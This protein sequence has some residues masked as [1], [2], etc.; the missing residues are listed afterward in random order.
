MVGGPHS[1]EGSLRILASLARV[2]AMISRAD[3]LRPDETILS[4]DD[5]I[6][7]DRRFCG[8]VV[9]LSAV[10]ASLQ[11]FFWV[12]EGRGVWWAAPPRQ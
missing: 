12:N 7:N 9:S 2:R 11:I 1:L 10:V 6:I 3:M 5:G 8:V 4:D